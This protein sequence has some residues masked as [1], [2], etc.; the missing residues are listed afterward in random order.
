MEQDNREIVELSNDYVKL[1]ILEENNETTYCSI[2]LETEE[3]KKRYV[4]FP[5][6]HLFHVICFEEYLNYYLLHQIDK[7]SIACPIC[8]KQ[9]STSILRTTFNVCH[10]DSDDDLTL[11]IPNNIY[12]YRYISQQ[13]IN[14]RVEIICVIIILLFMLLYFLVLL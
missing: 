1:D 10:E 13:C 12:D 4:K 5:C 11:I 3:T 2:C 8:R 7:E 14:K 9:I 6:T